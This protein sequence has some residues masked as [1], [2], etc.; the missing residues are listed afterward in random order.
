M[1][2]LRRILLRRRSPR[3]LFAAVFCAMVLNGIAYVAHQHH[4]EPGRI[5]GTHTELCG[6]CASF[7]GMHAAPTVPVGPFAALLPTFLVAGII[8]A[9][10]LLRRP[11]TA[12]RPRAPPTH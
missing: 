11:V 8:L 5:S 2:A 9:A 4:E 12:A 7:G 6:Y 3:L 1:S 10:P